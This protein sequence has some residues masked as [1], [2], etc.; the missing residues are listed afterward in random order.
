MNDYSPIL[1][2]Q[3]LGGAVFLVGLVFAQHERNQRRSKNGGD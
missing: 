2:L 3:I 1:V